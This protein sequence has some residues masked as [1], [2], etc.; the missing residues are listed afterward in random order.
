[1]F[2]ESLNSLDFSCGSRFVVFEIGPK[3]IL[4]NMAGGGGWM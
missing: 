2:E 4:I 1:L 3:P